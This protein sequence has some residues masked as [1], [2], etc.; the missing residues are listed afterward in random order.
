MLTLGCKKKDSYIKI[1]KLIGGLGDAAFSLGP[2]GGVK[3]HVTAI[4]GVKENVNDIIFHGEIDVNDVVDIT[5]PHHHLQ[6]AL[7]DV[8]F[9]L[10]SQRCRVMD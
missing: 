10:H 1:L 5:D 4:V 7:N 6:L 3:V 8:T 9:R 2:V